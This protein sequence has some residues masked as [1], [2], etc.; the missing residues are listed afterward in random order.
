[1]VINNIIVNT[2][3]GISN[4]SG[5]KQHFYHNSIHAKYYGIEIN[6]LVNASNNDWKN[7]II[8]VAGTWN[9][10]V[11]YDNS[12]TNNTWDYNLYHS[13][14]PDLFFFLFNT[15][16]AYAS[17]QSSGQDIHSVVQDPGFVSETDLHPKK[18]GCDKR[19]DLSRCCCCR[20][21]RQYPEQSTNHGCL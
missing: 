19:G 15:P 12:G 4:S 18:E 7:N 16:G 1:M 14:G 21:S 8:S 2:G 3:T 11:I 5:N 13:N 6:Y 20:Y 17:W 9:A 10:A